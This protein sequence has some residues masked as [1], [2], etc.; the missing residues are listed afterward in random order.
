MLVKLYSSPLLPPIVYTVQVMQRC[1]CSLIT[2]RGKGSSPD[3]HSTNFMGH[4]L[5]GQNGR[6][7]DLSAQT[8]KTPPPSFIV[9]IKTF[10]NC[11]TV[12]I[13]LTFGPLYLPYLYH[14]QDLNKEETHRWQSGA[15]PC[16]YTQYSP[17]FLT[18]RP[19]LHP[20]LCTLNSSGAA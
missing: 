5:L 19:P 10:K 2:Q 20:L 14:K 15:D 3:H 9:L 12:P 13:F 17:T 7:M 1:S 11:K 4:R 16:C 18:F 6:G 8:N